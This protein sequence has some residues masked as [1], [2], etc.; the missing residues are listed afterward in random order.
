MDITSPG[1]GL[2]HLG[3]LQKNGLFHL[4]S[5]ACSHLLLSSPTA[6]LQG[7]AAHLPQAH[8][9]GKGKAPRMSQ[10]HQ[11]SIPSCCTGAPQAL[12]YFYG[13]GKAAQCPRNLCHV[14]WSTRVIKMPELF[15]GKRFREATHS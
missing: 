15:L 1:A 8:S 11:Y 12:F 6:A 3:S 2:P 13:K 9:T 14:H 5:Q 10:A 4:P 7:A